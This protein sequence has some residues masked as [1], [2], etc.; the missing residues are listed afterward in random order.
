MVLIISYSGGRCLAELRYSF[1][2]EDI[3][4]GNKRSPFQL[5]AVKAIDWQN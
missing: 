4:I 3:D 5:D 1:S 2:Y